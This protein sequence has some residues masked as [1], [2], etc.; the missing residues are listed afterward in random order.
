MTVFNS[1]VGAQFLF[2][3]LA[4]GNVCVGGDEAGQVAVDEQRFALDQ[5][6][7]AIGPCPLEAMGLELARQLGDPGD[8]LGGVA[9]SVFAAF[10]R[11]A[12]QLGKMRAFA[13]AFRRQVQDFDET[14]IPDPQMEI[15]VENTDSL[16][17]VGQ[18]GA[19][20]G[21]AAPVVVVGQGGVVWHGHEF[22]L[23]CFIVACR[24]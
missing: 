6:S 10:S 16:R 22:D 19:Q 3:G 4:L 24:Q 9:R 14:L 7:A 20:I 13:N 1:V 8:V 23:P 12:D 21:L 2:G 18:D 15:F 17:H 11:N 5:V